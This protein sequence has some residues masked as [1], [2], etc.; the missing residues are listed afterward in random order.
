MY[1]NMKTDTLCL[2]PKFAVCNKQFS[3]GTKWQINN[4]CLANIKL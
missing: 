2:G 4:K 1:T 3:L